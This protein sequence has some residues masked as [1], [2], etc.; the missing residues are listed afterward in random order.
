MKLLISAALLCAVPSAP[1]WAQGKQ[2][3]VDRCHQALLA[4][5][6]ASFA[7]AASEIQAWQYV[8]AT[9]VV[10]GATACLSSGLGEPWAYSSVAGRF[11]PEAEIADTRAR[12]LAAQRAAEDAL[13]RKAAEEA[14]LAEWRAENASNVMVAVYDSCRELLAKDRIAALTNSV[15]VPSFLEL[16]LPE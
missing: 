9:A 5:D 12:K 7:A 2:E 16:G 6:Q 3:T 14:R 11:L 4:G 8:Y 10:A 15:C 1:A 13:E